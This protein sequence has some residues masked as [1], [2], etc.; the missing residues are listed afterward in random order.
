[1]PSP[2][3]QVLRHSFVR[4][5]IVGGSATGVM[6]LLVYG[7]Q[8]Q[9]GMSPFA[10]TLMASLILV[11]ST[12]LVQRSWAFRSGARHRTAFPRY[13]VTQI[14]A[15]LLT[16]FLTAYFSA[17]FS[18]GVIWLSSLFAAICAGTCSFVLGALWVF[19]KPHATQVDRT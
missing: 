7:M 11:P 4:F 15:A 18:P 8:W 14:V 3:D 1:M 12:Y 10:A 16:A 2:M 6:F 13:L 5:A 9:F 19:G 17:R